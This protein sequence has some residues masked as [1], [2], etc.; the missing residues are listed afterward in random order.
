MEAGDQIVYSAFDNRA[1]GENDVVCA[2]WKPA[3]P[4]GRGCP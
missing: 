2:D 1:V 4:I 3:G